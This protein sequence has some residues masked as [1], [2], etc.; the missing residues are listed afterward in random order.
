MGGQARPSPLSD[1]Q[2]RLIAETAYELGAVQRVDELTRL[3]RWLPPLET[4]LEVGCDAGGTL[5][6]WSQLAETVYGI[7]LPVN[8][9]ESWGTNH[10]LD[11]HGASV[12]FADS[13]SDEAKTWARSL[14][15]D[16][17]FIDADHTYEGVKEDFTSYAPQVR[18][19][20]WVVLHDIAAVDGIARFWSELDGDKHEIVRT[21]NPYGF[22]IWTK[23]Q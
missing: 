18:P 10:P 2:S 16:L 14:T 13:H 21:R 6:V 4:V 22:G 7:T 20:G 11:N 17:L 12:Y 3:I 9:L 23:E 5:Y 15:V 1:Q 19:G 8:T